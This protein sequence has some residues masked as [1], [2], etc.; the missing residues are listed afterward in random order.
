MA[1]FVNKASVNAGKV[2][3][4]STSPLDNYIQGTRYCANDKVYVN[5]SAPPSTARYDQGARYDTNGA[6]YVHNVDVL[7]PP[8]NPSG[9]NGFVSTGEGALVVTTTKPVVQYFNG[10]PLSQEGYVCVA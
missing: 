7:G 3:I 10:I 4:A 8:P 5:G 1:I 9:S 6:V 2:Q